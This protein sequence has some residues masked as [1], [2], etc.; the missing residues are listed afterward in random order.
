[1]AFLVCIFLLFAS[2]AHGQIEFRATVD[3]T[4]LRVGDQ[5]KLTL[6]ARGSASGIPQPAAPSLAGLEIAA[7]PF[8]STELQILN[9]RMS[10][11]TVYTYI[12]RATTPGTG[13]IGPST[14]TFKGKQ[15]ATQPIELQISDAAQ[16]APQ[17]E[18]RGQTQDVFIRVR[19]DKRKVYQNERILLTYT[20][21]FRLSITSPEIV[22]LPRTA[23]FWAEE[24]P[25]PRDLP[26]REEVIGGVQYRTAVFKQMALFPTQTGELTVEPLVFRTQVEMRSRRRE[27]FGLFNDP[28]FGMGVR[29]ETREIQSPSVTIDVE[30]LPEPGQPADFSGAVGEFE[31]EAGLDKTT[32]RAH[33]PVTLIF[34]IRGEGN[35]KTLADPKIAFPPDIEYYDPKVTDDIRRTGGQVSGSKTFEYLLIPRAAGSQIIPPISYSY[36]HPQTRKYYS[37]MTAGLL[38]QVE[39]G[40]ET[41]GSTPGIPVATK[42]GVE[43]IGE[44]IAYVKVKS[45]DFHWRGSA[46][47]REVTFWLILAAPWAAAAIVVAQR[48]RQEELERSPIRR[49]DLLALKH[50]RRGFA[51]AQKRLERAE[52]ERFCGTV[53][54]TLRAYLACRLHRESDNLSMTEL[55]ESW[56]ERDWP[57]EILDK[58][59]RVLS[60]CDFARFA[61]T[62]LSDIQ[63]GEILQEAKE[64][65]AEVERTIAVARSNK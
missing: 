22:R 56:M 49:R 45:N 7:G 23:G 18:Q 33:E 34:K 27:P 63:G 26:I 12:L 54:G 43:Q 24:I 19:A 41:G 57:P 44:D 48:R 13:K 25:L 60:E 2:A 6:E 46:P 10:G 8:R 47:H 65:V 36:F 17:T 50:A 52:T 5:V 30:S 53:A 21:C 61:S 62:Q 1:M 4:Q 38:L 16:P 28:F 58:V 29:A 3:R 64:I 20:V 11:S 51:Q 39:K 32:T 9:G 35:I 42:R 40:M 31:I 37:L 55:E 59:R 15:F 14:L